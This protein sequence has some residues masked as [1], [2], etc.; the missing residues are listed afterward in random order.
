MIPAQA[1]EATITAISTGLDHAFAANQPGSPLNQV[2][3]AAFFT[4]YA[5]T[6]RGSDVASTVTPSGWQLMAQR[7]ERAEQI[8][9]PLYNQAPQEGDMISRAMMPVVLGEQQPRD[10]LE[11]WFQRG[12]KADPDNFSVYMAKRWYLLPRWYGSDEDVWAF[13][14]ECAQSDNWAAKIPMILVEAISDAGDRDPS[15]YGRPEIWGRWKKFIAIIFSAI[16]TAFITG[17]SSRAMPRKAATGTW[18]RSSS[19][20]SA[21]IGTAP[22][23]TVTRNTRGCSPRPRR[24]NR[25]YFTAPNRAG[26]QQR[27]SA[28][29]T[30]FFAGTAPNIRLS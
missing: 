16:P 13:G 22:S 7:L 30:I 23:S 9:V 5:W 6:A 21:A 15:V 26:G 20:F 29:P 3:D 2:V 12:I 4:T 11:L 10:Q 25:D 24:T 1:D 17:A 19:K 28:R 14:L 27:N 18:P 8:L